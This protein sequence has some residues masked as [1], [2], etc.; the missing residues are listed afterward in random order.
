MIK[1]FTSNNK[2]IIQVFYM[3]RTLQGHHQGF[4]L[5]HVIKTLRTLLVSQLMFTK[6]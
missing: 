6:I 3:F 4:L 5:N 1:Q 2:F